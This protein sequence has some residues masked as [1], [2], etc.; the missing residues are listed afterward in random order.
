MLAKRWRINATAAPGGELIR[1]LEEKG[2][3]RC[4][5]YSAYRMGFLIWLQQPSLLCLALAV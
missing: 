5:L 2:K 4:V 3:R 1:F